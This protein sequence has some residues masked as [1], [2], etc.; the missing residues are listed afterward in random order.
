[1]SAGALPA[2]EAGV[3]RQQALLQLAKRAGEGKLSQE[4][5]DGCKV[6]TRLHF[7]VK[8]QELMFFFSTGTVPEDWTHSFIYKKVGHASS[9]EHE[10]SSSSVDLKSSVLSNQ[11]V[12]IVPVEGFMSGLRTNA[13]EQQLSLDKENLETW[14]NWG[15]TLQRP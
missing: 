4:D 6:A 8:Q 7:D 15:G 10:S 11:S 1:M 9:Q 5:K 12:V 14:C 13:S 2:G 3:E